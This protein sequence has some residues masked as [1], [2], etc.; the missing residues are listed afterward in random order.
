MISRFV[1]TLKSLKIK[2]AS[3]LLFSL[4]ISFSV[5]AQH[6]FD[7]PMAGKSA[8]L[9]LMNPTAR[10]L[11][12][13][14]YLTDNKI[15]DLPDDYQLIGFYN[16]S[17]AYDFRQTE[18]FI[19]ESGRDNLFLH[20]CSVLPGETIY[21]ENPCSDDFRK[22]FAGSRGIIFFGGPD[23][24]PTL[25]GEETMLLTEITDYHRHSFEAS[26]LFHLL[27]GFQDEAYV[28]LLDQKPE[29]MILGICLGMQTMNIATGG[30]LVQDIPSEI[31][32]QSTVEQ[33]L[34]V[35]EDNRHRNYHSNFGLE[36]DLLWGSFH[37]INIIMSDMAKDFMAGSNP[38]PYVLSSHH[39]AADRIGKGLQV[40][41]TSMD[42][43]V[44]EMM[45]HE[46]YPN[47]LGV[48]F[49]PEPTFL[50]QTDEKIKL[51]PGKSSEQ[52]F[53]DLHGGTS[54]ETFNRNIWRWTGDVLME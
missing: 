33:V 12:T 16:A 21:A 19:R 26:F 29:Y 3:V 38:N 6:F 9:V 22:V 31:Y 52:S 2:K 37:P 14:L 4:F 49:H 43:K 51:Q 25:Y 27:G 18:E 53:I 28:P 8:N 47:V 32:Q 17:Q 41:A 46:K 15:L 40:I 48:Q 23:I 10:N 44:V 45:A 11:K 1:K 36:E 13:I 34:A 35:S 42:G 50:Y 5:S 39:Q 7:T 20:E 30:T 24:P 54:G